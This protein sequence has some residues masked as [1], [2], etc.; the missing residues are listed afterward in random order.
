MY[1]GARGG[2][3]GEVKSGV[4]TMLNQ[5]KHLVPSSIFVW[6]ISLSAPP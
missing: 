5:N 3:G 4:F 1:A 2:E 6:Y